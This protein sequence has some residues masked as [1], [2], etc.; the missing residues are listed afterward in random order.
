MLRLMMKMLNVKAFG[1][2]YLKKNGKIMMRKM[3]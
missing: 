3:E 2:T 1:E